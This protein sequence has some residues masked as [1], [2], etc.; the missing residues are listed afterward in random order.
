MFAERFKY[1]YMT[2]R[3]NKTKAT[4]DKCCR[5]K[6]TSVAEQKR[7]MLQ[8]KSDKCGRAKP[9]SSPCSDKVQILSLF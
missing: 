4:S 7:Q 2:Q 9:P 1:L 6:A 5:A 3:K 8:S